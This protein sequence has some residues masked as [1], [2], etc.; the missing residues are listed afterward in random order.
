MTR[1]GNTAAAQSTSLMGD[2]ISRRDLALELDLSIDTLRRWHKKRSGP[3]C[4]HAGRAVY[5]RRS[6]VQNW[7]QEQEQELEVQKPRR[8]RPAGRR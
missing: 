1:S 6:A 3:P 5:Y 4:V 8:V 7:L 2:W